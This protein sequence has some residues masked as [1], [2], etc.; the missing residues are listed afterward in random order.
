MEHIEAAIY[1]ADRNFHNLSDCNLLLAR[2]PMV[3]VAAAASP[4]G[5]PF[6]EARC[7][8]VDSSNAIN[9]LMITCAAQHELLTSKHESFIYLLQ[10]GN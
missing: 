3:L 10:W 7:F 9:P 6:G 8:P 5:G 2:R 1:A 4:A